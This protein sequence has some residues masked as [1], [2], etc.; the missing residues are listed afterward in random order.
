MSRCPVGSFLLIVFFLVL[1]AKSSVT[2]G[3]LYCATLHKCP[4]DLSLRFE[5]IARRDD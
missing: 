2:T 1:V 5:W 3:E 4:G